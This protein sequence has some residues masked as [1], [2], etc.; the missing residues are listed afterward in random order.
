[1][2]APTC[3]TP[4]P[5]E[6][7]CADCAD[8]ECADADEWAIV[9]I[10]ITADNPRLDGSHPRRGVQGGEAP[11]A[12]LKPSGIKLDFNES[13]LQLPNFSIKCSDQPGIGIIQ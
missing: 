2:D 5:G 11:P 7:L 6:P 13:Q 4:P 9:Q 10:A 12:R 1:M 8:H 3:D